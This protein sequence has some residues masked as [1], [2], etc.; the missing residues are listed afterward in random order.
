MNRKRKYRL[1]KYIGIK[2]VPELGVKIAL[3]E[4]ATQ[5]FICL[6]TLRNNEVD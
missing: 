5:S 1:W 3:F 6:R 4:K 2:I